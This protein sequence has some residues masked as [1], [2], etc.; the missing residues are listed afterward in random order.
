MIGSSGPSL[1]TPATSHERTSPPPDPPDSSRPAKPK[2][3]QHRRKRQSPSPGNTTGP[4]SKRCKNASAPTKEPPA[5][6]N[7]PGSSNPS[8][9]TSKTD[10]PYD[11]SPG[12]ASQSELILAAA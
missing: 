7:A 2:M 3:L 8:T 1:P 12:A 11:D 9:P 10:K 4:P 6:A 5:T